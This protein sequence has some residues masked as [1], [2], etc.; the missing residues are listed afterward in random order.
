MTIL[1]QVRNAIDGCYSERKALR[2]EVAQLKEHNATLEATAVKT[3]KHLKA[4]E[5]QVAE[6][7]TANESLT[8]SLAARDGELAAWN[9][10]GKHVLAVSQLA[11]K[12]KDQP[13]SRKK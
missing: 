1:E 12:T 4:V 10:I 8:A 9:D 5:T 6:L 3:A 11:D 7:K 2:A 13:A